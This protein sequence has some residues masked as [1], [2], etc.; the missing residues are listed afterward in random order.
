MAIIGHHATANLTDSRAPK[1]W[2]GVV[3]TGRLQGEFVV[4]PFGQHV[5]GGLSLFVVDAG[6]E[7]S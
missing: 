3:C 7:A 6:C 1:N 5:A 4:N 2:C